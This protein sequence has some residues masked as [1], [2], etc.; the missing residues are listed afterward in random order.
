MFKS[1]LKWLGIDNERGCFGG[2][3]DEPE[4]IR[5]PDPTPA[6]TPAT[7][8]PTEMAEQRKSKSSA[9]RY[10]MLSTIRNVGGASGIAGTGTNLNAPEA[11]GQ[12]KSLGA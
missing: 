5:V 6:P 8:S 11:Q 9:M 3:P 10:G 12:K 7:I 1:F 2:S 4:P